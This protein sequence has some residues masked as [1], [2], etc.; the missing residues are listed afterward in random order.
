M[1][2]SSLS[3]FVLSILSSSKLIFESHE[4]LD[5]SKISWGIIPSPEGGIVKSFIGLIN[6]NLK[7]SIPPY[8]FFDLSFL[9]SI[10]QALDF[11]AL[12][13]KRGNRESNSFSFHDLEAR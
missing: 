8:G 11:L 2:L 3:S 10:L 4:C 6:C 9:F 1:Y 13:R 12:Q 5:L 7:C